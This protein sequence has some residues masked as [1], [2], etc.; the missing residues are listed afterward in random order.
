[1]V[2]KLDDFVDGY[3]VVPDFE[4][5]SYGI[6]TVFRGD[7]TDPEWNRW[8]KLSGVKDVVQFMFN[9][10]KTNPVKKLS[11]A[12]VDFLNEKGVTACRTMSDR[13]NC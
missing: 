1:M 3:V 6:D 13:P 4:A 7:M 5:G 10:K 2:L 9:F 8:R 12:L 11:K